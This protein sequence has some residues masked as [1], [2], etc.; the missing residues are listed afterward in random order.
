LVQQ[1]RLVIVMAI[2]GWAMGQVPS[3]A[4]IALHA[5]SEDA[6]RIRFAVQNNH[7]APIT[8]YQVRLQ[9]QCPDGTVVEAGGWSFDTTR[10]RAAQTDLGEFAPVA[11]ETID[12]G[13]IHQFEIVRPIEV[14][15]VAGGAQS[16]ETQTCQPSTLKDFTAI[17]ADGSGVGIR[18]L[19]DKQFVI[20]Q[21]QHQ[22]LK[23]WFESIHE[24]QASQNTSAAIKGLRDSLNQ[25]YDDCEDRPLTDARLTQCQINRE[26]WH[27]VNSIWQRVRSSPKADAD[28]VAHLIDYWNRVAELLQ[29]QLSHRG[30]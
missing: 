4:R 16:A 18:E 14:S 28:T 24:L 17:F 3:D 8:F 7:S 15:Q 19:I 26:I 1:A 6:N 13:K 25:E 29:Q 9:A 21:V 27:Q 10:T 30:G 23:R 22:E 12:P 20:W 5:Y 11:V 2:A